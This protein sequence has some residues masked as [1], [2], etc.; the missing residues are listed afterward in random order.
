MPKKN[1][2]TYT[3]D[4]IVKMLMDESENHTMEGQL[5]KP[6]LIRELYKQLGDPTEEDF[7]SEYEI[8]G[9]CWKK[10]AGYTKDIDIS[11]ERIMNNENNASTVWY[12]NRASMTKVN[13]VE[14]YTRAGWSCAVQSYNVLCTKY[15]KHPRYKNIWVRFYSSRDCNKYEYV[16]E[17]E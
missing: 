12:I 13:I 4:E 8:A 14:R 3:I 6:K 10:M 2:N 11:T 15:V 9:R 5:I 17:T 16:I 1:N 7:K